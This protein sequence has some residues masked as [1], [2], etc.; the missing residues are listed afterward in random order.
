MH[1]SCTTLNIFK[2]GLFAA[3]VTTFVV[4][5]SQALQPDNA[6]ISANLLFEMI[7][8]Q[9]AVASG[10]SVGDIAASELRPGT[11]T[12]SSLDYWVN[13][14]WYLSLLLGLFAVPGFYCAGVALC[15]FPVAHRKLSF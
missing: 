11:V 15:T 8:I 13:R 9:R 14:L 2:S 6:E 7:A 1:G 12:A 4:Q 3:V 10:S 5:S